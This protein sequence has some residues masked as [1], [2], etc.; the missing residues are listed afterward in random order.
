MKR[1]SYAV[2]ESFAMH[3][4]RLCNAL[5]KALQCTAESF[6]THCGELCSALRKALQRVALSLIT[7][8]SAKIFCKPQER[9]IFAYRYERACSAPH[10]QII[11]KAGSKEYENVRSR[12][13]QERPE[14]AKAPSPRQRLGYASS[15]RVLSPCKGKS[16]NTSRKFISA[17][18]P[19][20]RT[21][22][23]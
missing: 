14:G 10:S 6:A 15:P 5:Q 22:H 8:I 23:S 3:C 17:F 11:K 9:R 1:E 18:A 16:S 13:I 4:G 19:S 12:S 20:G 2:A 21:S 7:K